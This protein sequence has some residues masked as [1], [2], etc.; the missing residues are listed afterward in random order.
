MEELHCKVGKSGPKSG[1]EMNWIEIL[2]ERKE[3]TITAGL[4][5]VIKK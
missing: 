1:K 2:K 4:G 3:L 5:K